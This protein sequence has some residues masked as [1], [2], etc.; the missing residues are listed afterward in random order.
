MT[1]SPIIMK[2]ILRGR[3]YDLKTYSCNW[4][5]REAFLLELEEILYRLPR[6]L[7]PELIP[8]IESQRLQLVKLIKDQKRTEFLDAAN[9]I[10]KYLITALSEG[11]MKDD[12]ER[13]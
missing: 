11:I 8:E 13:E 9:D 6:A 4:N 5:F 10:S 3:A 7:G 2:Y 1:T 12:N